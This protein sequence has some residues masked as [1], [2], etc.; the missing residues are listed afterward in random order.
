VFLFYGITVQNEIKS[1]T[2]Y[3]SMK[4][5]MLIFVFNNK[6]IFVNFLGK[7][8]LESLSSWCHPMSRKENNF[9]I[10]VA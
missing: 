2:G 8:V 5:F 6:I 1:N 3:G 7:I 10:Y 4:Y 9:V